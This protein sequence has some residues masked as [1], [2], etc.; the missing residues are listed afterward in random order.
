MKVPLIKADLPEF[1]EVESQLREI[2]SN[3]R[4][5]N[6]GKY[7]TQFEQEAAA[8]LG[9]PV[10]TTSSATAGLILTLQALGLSPG[11]KVILPSFTFVASAQAV[12][13]AG[14][15]PVFAEID[16]DLNI[17]ASDVH[18]LLEHHRDA[19]FVIPIHMYGMSCRTDA[20]QEA[21]SEVSRKSDRVIRV[22]YDAA[23]AFGSERSGKRAG[24]S[25]DAEVFSLSVT[26]LMTSVEGG[27]IASRNE[28]LIQRLKKMRNYGI[29]EN[30]NAYWPGLNGKMSEFHAIIGIQNLRHLP[31]L[32]KKRA[33]NARYYTAA[34]EQRTAS[35]V[36]PLRKEAVHTFKD[37]TVMV[38]P[39]LKNKRDSIMK[40]LADRGVE[41][42]AYFYPPVH[43]QKFF[44]RFA[45][46]ALPLTED[47]SRR[48][49]TLPFYTTISEQEMDY[50]VDS[51]AEA[52]R[53]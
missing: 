48:V 12:L 1:S 45:D 39:K 14:G 21:V 53:L 4:I 27:M 34:I 37:F 11:A 49:I 17:S 19:S 40:S 35:R 31:E 23:H 33:N 5:T 52:E 41:T 22:V 30:Y 29:E 42:R 10:L 24:S 44:Q 6:F 51:L 46:R 16:D 7:V 32:L 28:P 3:G 8:Y 18:R 2:L 13:Y 36:I 25:G 50:V 20:I 43:E 9:T 38:P 15:I 26:K 47:F